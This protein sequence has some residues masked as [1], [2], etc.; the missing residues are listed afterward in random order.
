MSVDGLKCARCGKEVCYVMGPTPVAYSLPEVRYYDVEDP[1]HI[2][3]R[4]YTFCESC[5][6]KL[7]ETLGSFLRSVWRKP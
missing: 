4:R 3:E 7:L 5:A 1:R 2:Q 6:R